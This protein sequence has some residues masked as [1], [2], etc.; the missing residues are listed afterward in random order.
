MCSQP[1]S[2]SCAP[3]LDDVRERAPGALAHGLVREHEAALLAVDRPGDELQGL[4]GAGR[5][6]KGPWEPASSILVQLG[7]LRAA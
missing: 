2:L 1:C 5:A 7:D 6:S 4:G 3:L